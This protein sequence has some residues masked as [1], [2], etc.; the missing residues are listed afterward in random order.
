M[1]PLPPRPEEVRSVAVSLPEERAFQEVLNLIRAS[2]ERALATVNSAL[3]DLYWKVG[4][5]VA[6]KIHADGWGKG[7]VTALSASIQKGHPGLHGFSPQNL[8]RMRQ[9]F[10]V[11]RDRPDL[12]TLL[13]ELPWSANL[14]VLTKCKGSEEREFYLRMASGQRWSVRQIA[15]KYQR[16]ILPWLSQP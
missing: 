12:S 10:E 16:E 5:F 3:I 2:R 11:Y 4:E 9:F 6:Q 1:M 7:T 8:W 15:R 14:H 13:R